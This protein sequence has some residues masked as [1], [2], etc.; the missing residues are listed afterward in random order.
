MISLKTKENIIMKKYAVC[1]IFNN[2]IQG[3]GFI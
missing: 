1:H 2:N 3:S